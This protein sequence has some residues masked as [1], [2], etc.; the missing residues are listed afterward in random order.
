MSTQPKPYSFLNLFNS[1]NFAGKGL[2]F[3]DFPVAQGTLTA[4]NGIV[5]GDGTYSNSNVF[6]PPTTATGLPSGAVWNNGG[7]LAI[8][9]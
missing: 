4:P 8:V 3:T 7:T 9:P 1:S 2:D 6:I 5:W